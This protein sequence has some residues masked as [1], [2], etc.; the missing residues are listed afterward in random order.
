MDAVKP[1]I[2]VDSINLDVLPCLG[3]ELAERVRQLVGPITVQRNP[4][5]RES[6]AWVH[7]TDGG[8][9]VGRISSPVGISPRDVRCF[10]ISVI[11]PIVYVNRNVD[12]LS[13]QP[14]ASSFLKY[15]I[16]DAVELVVDRVRIK[17]TKMVEQCSCQRIS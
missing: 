3:D 13:E 1:T 15:S 14:V 11:E 9:F 5:K 8:K 16:A 4:A 2:E 6:D 10:A 7:D 17:S 12:W